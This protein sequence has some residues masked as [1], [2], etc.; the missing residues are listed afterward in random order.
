MTNRELKN[1]PT[2]LNLCMLFI[3][4]ARKTNEVSGCRYKVE[5]KKLV[6]KWNRTKN[7]TEKTKS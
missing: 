6:D 7:E 1:N 4:K 3:R 5:S 2:E